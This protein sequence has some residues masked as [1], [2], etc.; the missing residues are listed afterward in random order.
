MFCS[1]EQRESAGE[2]RRREQWNEEG[3]AMVI[4]EEV[5]PSSQS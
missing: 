5:T 3:R 1:S 4:S 2:E